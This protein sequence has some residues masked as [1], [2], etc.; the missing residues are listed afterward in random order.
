MSRVNIPQIFLGGGGEFFAIVRCRVAG[1]APRAVAAVAFFSR[2]RHPS[3]SYPCQL[4]KDSKIF[5]DLSR[6]AVIVCNHDR[7]VG[8]F[9]AR[10]LKKM[11]AENPAGIF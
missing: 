7:K 2:T 5:L 8:N 10:I 11:P 3:R 9:F 1:A 6:S 4:S